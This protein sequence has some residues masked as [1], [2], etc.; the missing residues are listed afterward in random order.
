MGAAQFTVPGA[1]DRLRSVREAPDLQLHPNEVGPPLVLAATDPAQPYGAA[2]AWPISTGRPA[3]SAAAV[4]V[5]RSGEPLVWHDRRGHSLV[6]FPA[7]VSDPAWAEALAALVKDGRARS[8]E[9]RKINGAAVAPS[10]AEAEALREDERLRQLK[11]T[12]LFEGPIANAVRDAGLWIDGKD[13]AWTILDYRPELG[14]DYVRLADEL[15]ARLGDEESR[16]R[17]RALREEMVATS[18]P[19]RTSDAA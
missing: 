19:E 12:P 10:S 14:G 15:L 4:V 17:L 18:V 2:L 9:V 8:L 6:T 1:V 13:P 3:R 16:E 5:L 7:A 11:N